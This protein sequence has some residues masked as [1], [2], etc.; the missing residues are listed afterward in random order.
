MQYKTD[1]LIFARVTAQY[2]VWLQCTVLLR[3]RIPFDIGLPVGL[4]GN[5]PSRV[6]GMSNSPCAADYAPRLRETRF[7][8]ASAPQSIRY[9][10]RISRRV[11]LI[12][13]GPRVRPRDV[14]GS[15]VTLRN[16][17][18]SFSRRMSK[19]L[20]T[21]EAVRKSNDTSVKN[22]FLLFFLCIKTSENDGTL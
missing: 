2:K 7:W 16:R 20:S 18:R 4:S 15:R 5:V 3:S 13:W 10:Q 8:K 21:G 19:E 22:W 9:S 12:G 6:S 1:N 17:L 11:L 14:V